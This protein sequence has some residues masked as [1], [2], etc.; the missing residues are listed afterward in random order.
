MDADDLVALAAVLRV[1]VPA[2]LLP[3]EDPGMPVSLASRMSVEWRT[4]WNWV[5]GETALAASQDWVALLPWRGTNQPYLTEE[6]LKQKP[7]E[8][9]TQF[10]V[11]A[12]EE[13][14]DDGPDS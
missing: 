6:E 3:H 4:A 5:R 8:R 10:S 13:M 14:N 12:W 7:F 1:S 2:L 9:L 11:E